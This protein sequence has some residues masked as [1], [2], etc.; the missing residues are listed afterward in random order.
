M[1]LGAVGLMFLLGIVIGCLTLTRLGDYY[2]RKPVYM[3]G[4]TMHLAIMIGL[5]FSKEIVLDFAL[6]FCLGLSVTARY[7]VGYTFNVEMQPRSHQVLVSTCQFLSEAVVGIFVCIYFSQ[8]S[9]DWRLLQIPN[10]TLTSVGIVFLM[11]MPESPRFLISQGKYW[12]ARE[13]FNRIAVCNGFP[14]G[15]ANN[16]QFITATDEEEEEPRPSRDPESASPASQ[17]NDEVPFKVADEDD[18]LNSDQAVIDEFRRPDWKD[19]LRDT[20][21]KRNLIGS[22]MLWACSSFN[23]YMLTFFLKY[24]PGNIFQNSLFFAGSDLLA[25]GLSG[26]ILKMTKVTTGLCIAFLVAICGG[27]IY[28]VFSEDTAMIPFMICLARVGITMSY[29]IGYISVNCLF[30]T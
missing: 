1:E 3:L 24:F 20:I 7:Y 23:F 2:G 19:M 17:S 6:L 21:L 13:V 8:L 27:V 28:L 29:N 14:S 10:V 11:M 15:W 30:P 5:I 12:Q 9:K 25:F 18:I 16:F 22:T 26:C 4:L